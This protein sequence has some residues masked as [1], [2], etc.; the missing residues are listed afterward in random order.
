L[1]R[2]CSL[3]TIM[4]KPTTSLALLSLLAALPAWAE[5]DQRPL[6]EVSKGESGRLVLVSQTDRRQ[7]E[8]RLES[9]GLRGE[10]RTG[11]MLWVD[12]R[13]DGG[14]VVGLGYQRRF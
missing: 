3:E 11:Q 12:R 4:T 2:T 1:Q 8:T 6:L 10:Y 9:V 5:A 14:T 13:Q 7:L